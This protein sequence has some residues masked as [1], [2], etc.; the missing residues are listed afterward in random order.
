MK[1]QSRE[2]LVTTKVAQHWQDDFDQKVDELIAIVNKID[3]DKQ[4]E[5]AIQV[6]DVYHNAA[7]DA[8]TSIKKKKIIKQQRPFEFL[9]FRN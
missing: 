2:L 4:V 7:H 1:Q 8:S 5:H 3:T 9:A 6:M